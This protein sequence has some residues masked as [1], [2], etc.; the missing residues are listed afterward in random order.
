MFQI[1]ELPLDGINLNKILSTCLN[2]I[3]VNGVPLM[4]HII[5]FSS[6]SNDTYGELKTHH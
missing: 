3:M 1:E 5:T 4:M 6:V 2:F